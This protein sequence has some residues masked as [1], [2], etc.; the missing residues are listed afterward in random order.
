MRIPEVFFFPLNNISQKRGIYT[1]ALNLRHSIFFGLIA[2]DN[3]NGNIKDILCH[4][5]IILYAIIFFSLVVLFRYRYI[6]WI[7]IYNKENSFYINLLNR[8]FLLRHIL[9]SSLILIYFLYS[10]INLNI[11]FKEMFKLFDLL[12]SKKFFIID[13]V[14]DKLG[15]N[16]YFIDETN[17]TDRT[18]YV[19]NENEEHSGDYKDSDNNNSNSSDSDPAK[20]RDVSPNTVMI[21]E[22]PERI[23]DDI[24]SESEFDSADDEDVSDYED[25][26]NEPNEKNGYNPEFSQKSEDIMKTK[27]YLNSCIANIND[28]KD[29]INEA[30]DDINRNISKNSHVD[31][32]YSVDNN[33][34][35]SLKRAREDD[36]MDIDTPSSKKIRF[37]DPKDKERFEADMQIVNERKKKLDVFMADY[38]TS[39]NRLEKLRGNNNPKDK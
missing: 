33:K 12:L 4:Y 29:A 7:M 39:E 13:F 2:E 34:P 30:I 31:D 9:F 3:F 35:K 14:N 5:N 38:R 24:I 25:D 11:E 28:A 18:H 36:E 32:N 37:N 22:L 10:Y 19:R 23:P 16:I 8:L 1:I 15:L 27:S 21:D 20:K 26:N 6:I 17:E